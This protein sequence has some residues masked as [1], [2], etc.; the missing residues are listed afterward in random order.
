MYKYVCYHVQLIFLQNDR[1]LLFFFNP[2][3][4]FFLNKPQIPL[5]RSCYKAKILG[6]LGNTHFP[7]PTMKT[8]HLSKNIATP[9]WQCSQSAQ[10]LVVVVGNFPIANPL[11]FHF[12][13]ASQTFQQPLILQMCINTYRGLLWKPGPYF[14]I[15]QLITW[16]KYLHISFI[17]KKYIHA[18]L[19]SCHLQWLSLFSL[20]QSICI[21]YLAVEVMCELN[22]CFDVVVIWE[23]RK[24]L[25]NV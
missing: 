14:F 15:W 1:I 17:V 19:N 24:I 22:T 4:L 11:L 7:K 3:P 25:N 12:Y 20:G 10:L 16:M 18:S 23:H 8:R 6:L 2:A 9:G 21:W 13:K 5:Y